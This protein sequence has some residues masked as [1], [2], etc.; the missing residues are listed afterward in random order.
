[1][2]PAARQLED[3]P[4]M[5][6]FADKLARYSRI[7][8]THRFP[9]EL[10][11]KLKASKT[12]FQLVGT[13]A[14]PGFERLER[15]LAR[16]YSF[17][18]GENACTVVNPFA[19]QKPRIRIVGECCSD[20]SGAPRQLLSFDR[21]RPVNEQRLLY[22]YPQG[23]PLDIG[24]SPALGLWV[25]GNGRD[26][27]LNVRLEGMYPWGVG[28]GDHVV[29]LNFTGWRYFSLCEIDNGDYAD[30]RFRN[31]IFDVDKHDSLY[32]R[33]RNPFSYEGIARIRFLFTDGGDGVRLG[34]LTAGPAS[35]A[36]IANPAVRTA[37]GTLTFHCD[38]APSQYLEYDPEKGKAFRFDSL[39][40]PEEVEVSGSATLAAGENTVSF[41]GEAAGTRRIKAH[42]LVH[43]ET[44]RDGPSGAGPSVA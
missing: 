42:F 41:I 9:P 27:Y 2:M 33:Y 6:R 8:E 17:A 39:G 36:P 31:D 18:P 23:E 26:E 12:G 34:E 30:M 28:F 14:N 35:L 16:P 44:L 20:A 11:E 3:C 7:R 29:S 43:G 24:E 38:V 40:F 13:D 21:E 32:R 5:G 15:L 22:E 25:M 19:S 10:L 4:A 37:G 1:M